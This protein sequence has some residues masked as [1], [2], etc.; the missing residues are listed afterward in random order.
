[1]KITIFAIGKTHSDYTNLIDDYLKRISKNVNIDLICL[2]EYGDEPKK[3]EAEII[4]KIKDKK[5]V[6]VLDKSGKEYSSEQFSS[7]IQSKIEDRMLNE[8]CFVI[9]GS[10]GFSAEFLNSVSTVMSLSIMTFTHQ[11]VRIILLEQIY[12][13]FEIIKGSRYHK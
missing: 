2:K 13:A 3:E 12:R 7:F 9:G 1:M 10:Q 5:F 8:I 6:V 11:M 4:S